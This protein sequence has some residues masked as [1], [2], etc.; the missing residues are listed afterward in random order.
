MA[1]YGTGA[2]VVTVLWIITPGAALFYDVSP[3][4]AALLGGLGAVVYGCGPLRGLCGR[5]LASRERRLAAGLLLLQLVLL[6][7]ATVFS[8]M[9]ALS[10][11]GSNWRRMGWVTEAGLLVFAFLV[12]CVRTSHPRASLFYL[13]VLAFSGAAVAAYAVLQFLH[14]DPFLPASSYR[15][16]WLESLRPPS[17]MGHPLYLANVLVPM[18]IAAVVLVRRGRSPWERR[19]A[20]FTAVLLSAATVLTGTRAAYLAILAAMA[21]VAFAPGPRRRARLIAAAVAAPL[22]LVLVYAAVT[23]GPSPIRKVA[24]RWKSDPQGGTRL[25]VWRDS[26]S[27]AMAPRPLGTGPE[28]FP[29]AFPV[30]ASKDLAVRYPNHYHESPHNVLLDIWL[31]RGAFAGVGFLVL[32]A[33]TWSRSYRV[34]DAAGTL[35]LPALFAASVVAHLSSVFTIPDALIFYLILGMAI[36]G[37]DGTLAGNFPHRAFAIHGTVA[38]IR[39]LALLGMVFAVQLSVAEW[40]LSSADSDFSSHHRAAALEHY[41]QAQTWQPAGACFDFW[42]GRKLLADPDPAGDAMQAINSEAALLVAARRAAWCS[43]Q[44]HNALLLLATVYANRG[45]DRPTEETLRRAIAQAPLWYELHFQLSQILLRLGCKDEALREA[46]LA[47]ELS[48]GSDPRA[49]PNF[50]RLAAPPETL[51]PLELPPRP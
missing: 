17:T 40:H 14:A 11:A 48:G 24:E 35:Y 32:V 38:A 15:I 16:D 13:R 29:A 3:K 26:L 44:R 39:V 12:A 9:P 42:F 41:A 10:V 49:H 19:C 46:A 6:T 50:L 36:G 34:A 18:L 47:D 31:S 21:T 25:P 20:G 1:L 8:T 7:L 23:M 37:M 51:V 28:T 4:A 27:M 30:F 2:V 22:L 5:L 33:L 45:Y 43:E